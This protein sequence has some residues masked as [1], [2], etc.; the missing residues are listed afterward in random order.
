MGIAEVLL[1]IGCA[2]LVIGVIVAAVVRK[3]K[4]K[5]SCDCGCD[6]SRCHLCSRDEKD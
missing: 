5:P 2:A 1:I 4:G 3:V 6:C